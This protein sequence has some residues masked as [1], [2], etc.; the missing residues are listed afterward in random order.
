MVLSMDNCNTISRGRTPT[1]S[2]KLQPPSEQQ[3]RP[4]ELV[5]HAEKN[6]AEQTTSE[7]PTSVCTHSPVTLSQSFETIFVSQ[8]FDFVVVTIK[9]PSAEYIAE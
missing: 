5:T 7:C 3:S 9:A 6:F 1:L 8:D 2:L 4:S